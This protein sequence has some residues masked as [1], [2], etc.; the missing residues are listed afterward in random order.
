MTIAAH[1]PPGPDRAG[2]TG[3]SETGR[4]GIRPMSR[5]DIP[6]IESMFATA[7]AGGRP[8]PG[9]ASYIETVY[10]GSP[11]YSQEHGSL[12]YD[13]GTKGI[14]AA[15]LSLPI[16]FIADGKPVM[17]RL[18]CAF[19]SD[20]SRSGML[21]AARL[22]RSLRADQV[23]LC[24]S[25]NASPV[26]ANHWLAGGGIVL[27]VESLEWR[28]AF[29]PVSAL[30]SGCRP[31]RLAMAAIA[32]LLRMLDRAVLAR[33]PWI[34]P[35]PARG[36]TTRNAAPQEFFDHAGPMTRRFA[37]R[38]VWTQQHFD[39]LLGII[40]MNRTLGPLHC[41]VVEDEAGRTI[42]AFLFTGRPGATARVM[43][44]I[45][46]ENR[47][48]DVT[49]QMFDCLAAEGFVAATGMNQPFMAAAIMR[50]RRLTF[51]HQGYLCLNTRHGPLLES[52][53][54]G[55]LYIGGLASESWS[56]L[57]TDF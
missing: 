5:A 33:R 4:S 1:L 15:L 19:M 22:A 10:F 23:E 13:N 31:P 54:R 39:W 27:P 12:V 9:L 28:R 42:G 52:A 26:S 34:R 48:F 45:C 21:G 25:D 43:N 56:R 57:V 49:A 17:A 38:P 32:P 7:F 20:G 3:T 35:V 44:L 30:V 18:L 51:R 36:C 8:T 2:E 6:A 14:T 24:F 16:P 47:E 37:V 29:Q 55:D 41:R 40:A 11:H 46:E 50:Q 53:R